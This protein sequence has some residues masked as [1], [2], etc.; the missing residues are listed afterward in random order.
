MPV[1]DRMRAQARLILDN[2]EG[3]A[4]H[5]APEQW[6]EIDDFDYLYREYTILAFEQDADRVADALR[7]ALDDTGYGDVPEGDA[8]Q[9]QRE[10]VP[11]TGRSREACPPDGAA[12]ADVVSDLVGRLDEASEAGWPS[13][14]TRF[15]C[16]PICVQRPSRLR[17]RVTRIPFR[18]PAR[19][20][21]VCR[22][23]PGPD[24][25]GSACRSASWTPG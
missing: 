25:T 15:T 24:T 10:R 18:P 13:Q 4:A 11:V 23:P 16:A 2:H 8:R 22:R 12:D 9:I 1:D 5:P 21:T 6:D 14:S 3:A 7:Q 17:C 19:M 20:Q